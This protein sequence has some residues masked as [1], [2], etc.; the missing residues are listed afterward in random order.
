M[1]LGLAVV[2]G[3]QNAK[4]FRNIESLKQRTAH[5]SMSSG[6]F[7]MILGSIE[8]YFKGLSDELSDVIL[9]PLHQGKLAV[10]S[11]VLYQPLLRSGWQSYHWKAL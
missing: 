9:A 1:T 5:S 11:A 2:V 4:Y 7:A 8:R 10:K 3:S 6:L